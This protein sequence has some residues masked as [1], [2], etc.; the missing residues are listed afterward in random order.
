MVLP[1]FTSLDSPSWI[2]NVD[3]CWSFH[4]YGTRSEAQ[5]HPADHL[6]TFEDVGQLPELFEKEPPSTVKHAGHYNK[7]RTLFES[8]RCR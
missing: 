7:F 2:P 6:Q 5:K 1:I 8:Q 3:L 4:Q